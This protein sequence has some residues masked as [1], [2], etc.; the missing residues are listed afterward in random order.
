MDQ[1]RRLCRGGGV[2]IT[3]AVQPEGRCDVA[4]ASKALEAVAAV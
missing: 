3:T 2:I 4:A 1:Y